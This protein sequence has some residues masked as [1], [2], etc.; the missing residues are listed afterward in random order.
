MSFGGF[1]GI[2]EEYHPLPW[3]VLKYDERQGG[4]VT[5]TM[6]VVPPPDEGPVVGDEGRSATA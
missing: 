5:G 6:P 3:E 4:Y 1:L 2:G